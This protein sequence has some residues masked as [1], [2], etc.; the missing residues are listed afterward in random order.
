MRLKTKEEIGIKMKHDKTTV[1]L[2][3]FNNIDYIKIYYNFNKIE[4]DNT[5][6]NVLNNIKSLHYNNDLIIEY[7]VEP[8]CI[9]DNEAF[10]KNKFVICQ[11]INELTSL[12]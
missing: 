1:L 6:E 7:T 5:V 11:L 4:I 2:Y 10:L 12:V 3:L 9:V 8:E